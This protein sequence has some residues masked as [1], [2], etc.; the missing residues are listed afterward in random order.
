[1]G[2]EEEEEGRDAPRG[3]Y[4]RRGRIF[5]RGVEAR[6]DEMNFSKKRGA[7]GPQIATTYLWR[8][9]KIVIGAPILRCPPEILVLG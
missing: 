6:V 2:N 1:M 5:T 3:N 4:S 7:A 9:V 8:R